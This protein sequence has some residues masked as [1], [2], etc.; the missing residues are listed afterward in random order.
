MADNDSKQVYQ[1]KLTICGSEPPIWRRLQIPADT[2]MDT[3]HLLFE[4]SM[5]WGG[6][7][8][9]FVSSSGSSARIPLRACTDLGNGTSWRRTSA[10]R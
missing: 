6:G 10:G 9:D 1:L 3:V 4:A 2:T 5:G 8:F 7:P